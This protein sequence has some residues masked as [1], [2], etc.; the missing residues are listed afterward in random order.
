PYREWSF[1]E[2]FYDLR[3]P[4]EQKVPVLGTKS[5]QADGGARFFLPLGEDLAPGR[6]RIRIQPEQG[7]NGY[8]SLYQLRPGDAPQTHFFVER[9]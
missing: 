1:T 5:Q 6:Y 4:D 8:L 7:I 9:I 3:I 2:R